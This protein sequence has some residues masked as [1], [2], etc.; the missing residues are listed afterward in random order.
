VLLILLTD[1]LIIIIA[2]GISYAWYNYQR[3]LRI[4]KLELKK[5]RI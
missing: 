1:I 5:E 3:K 2:V 4:R